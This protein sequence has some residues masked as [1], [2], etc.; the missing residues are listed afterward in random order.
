MNSPYWFELAVAF[1]L[2]CIGG[3]VLQSFAEGVPKWRRAAKMLLG[4][5]ISVFVSA[6]A[7][8]EWFFV[9]VGLVAVGVVAVH[10]WWLPKHGINGWTAEPKEKY[11]AL[12]RW[13]RP[14]VR[15]VTSASGR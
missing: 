5:A 2:T 12:R 13:K 9:M 14:P 15:L 6:T 4:G 10:C 1:G 7:G 8:R 11:Y 3:I